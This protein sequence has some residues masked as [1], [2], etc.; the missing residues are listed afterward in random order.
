MDILYSRYSRKEH[1][2]NNGVGDF[3][4]L[5]Q[6]DCQTIDRLNHKQAVN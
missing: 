1:E 3:S 2:E 4:S 5:L 6:R